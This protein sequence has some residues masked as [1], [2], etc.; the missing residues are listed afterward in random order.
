MAVTTAMRTQVSE[1]YVALFGRAPDAEGLGYWVEQMSNGRTWAQVAQD[2]YNTAPAR[3]YY[4]LS[5]TNEEI[6]TSFY[7]HVLGRQPDNEGKAYWTGQLNT[8]TEGQVVVDMITAVAN[9]TG[10]DPA[11]LASK[12]L[13]LNK[14]TVAQYYAFNLNGDAAGSVDAIADVTA[15]SNVSS[16]SN[17]EAL[18]SSGSTFVLTVDAPSVTEGNSGSKLLTF[19]LTLD[20]TP[21]QDV[22]VDYQT[23]TTGT[24][25]VNEDFVPGA[26]TVTFAAGQRTATVSV[27]VNG[28]TT[29]EA[30]ETIKVS[31]SGTKLAATVQGTGT[32]TNDDD[33]PPA[34]S[35]A[36]KTVGVAENSTTVTTSAAVDPD[37][38]QGAVTY[39]LTGDD[40]SK[41]AIDSNGNITFLV[42]PNYEAPGSNA[43][44]NAY[45]LTVNATSHGL[46]ASQTVTVNVTNVNENPTVSANSTSPTVNEN[47]TV[48]T[49]LTAGDPDSGDTTTYVLSGA[50]AAKFTIENGVLKFIT[51][52]DFETPTDAN[53][54]NV[55]AVSVQ[56]RDAG[57]LLSTAT[58]VNVT[59]ADVLETFTLT[60]SATDVIPGTPNDDLINGQVTDSLQPTTANTLHASDVIHGGDGND[61]LVVTADGDQP[62][63][64][65][66]TMDGVETLEV[67]SYT[68]DG[69][70]VGVDTGVTLGLV[71]VSGLETVES[72]N[73][74]SNI[75]LKYVQNLVDLDLS[76]NGSG[77]INVD[78]QYLGGAVAGASTQN[79]ALD[80]FG[81]T[82]TVGDVN[83]DGIETAAITTSGDA[84]DITLNSNDLTTVTVAGDQDLTLVVNGASAGLTTLTS[85]LT[86]AGLTATA[87]V[88]AGASVT[89]AAGDD[90]LFLSATAAASGGS[91]TV[92]AGEGD[93]TVFVDI[94][95]HANFNGSGDY[96][97][98]SSADLGSISVTTGDGDDTIVLL[99]A[100]NGGTDVTIDAGAGDNYVEVF[101]LT[102]AGNGLA[103]TV[104][105]TTGDG[106]DNI[107][108]GSAASLTVDMGN[109]TNTLSAG[110]ADTISITGGT[111]ADTV[112]LTSGGTLTAN[113]G[114]GENF[115]SGG[116]FTDVSITGG[117]DHDQVYIG[118]ADSVV[119]NTGDSTVGS[120]DYIWVGNVLSGDSSITTGNGNDQVYMDY[121][122]TG[123]TLTVALGEG[124]N[125]FSG[126]LF[127][128]I[129][130]TAGAGD[131]SITLDGASAGVNIDAGNGDNFV[132]IQN[133]GSG[134]PGTDVTITTGT[135][136]DLVWLGSAGNSANT[137]DT[138][139][140]TLGDG[141]DQIFIGNS[142]GLTGS[143]YTI[144]GGNGDDTLLVHSMDQISGGG[145]LANATSLETLV[146]AAVGSGSTDNFNAVSAGANDA[147]IV[148]YVFGGEVGST[149]YDIDDGDISGMEGDVGL[150]DVVDG[151]TVTSNQLADYNGSGNF[152]LTTVDADSEANWNIN[153]TG[154]N[155]GEDITVEGINAFSGGNVEYGQDNWGTVT[156]G[157]I[158]TF[159]LTVNDETNT[160]GG[161]DQNLVSGGSVGNGVY[162][163]GS[164]V[165]I[166]TLSA[167]DLTTLNIAGNASVDINS[168]SAPNLSM[169]DATDVVAGAVDNNGDTVAGNVS[170]WLD[171]V[172][173][174]IT[175]LTA[176]GDDSVVLSDTTSKIYA[177][178]GAGNDFVWGEDGNDTILTGAGDDLVYSMG[179]NDS[180]NTGE[181]NDTVVNLDGVDTIHTG[182]GDD[183]IY[184]S[185]GDYL[186]AAD[187][188]DGG[189]GYDEL[190]LQS[191]ITAAVDDNFFRQWSGVESVFLSGGSND[192]TLGWIAQHD[193]GI[194][195]VF[196]SNSGGD[197]LAL[198]VDYTT[199]LD[200]FLGT[201]SA[202]D[203]VD[204]SAMG[205]SGSLDVWATDHSMWH[206]G[207]LT[208]TLMGGDGNDTL[209]VMPIG[210]GGTVDLT[211]MHGFETV[212]IEVTP[213][214][215]GQASAADY[216]GNDV[217]LVFS[218]GN[219]SA[220]ETLVI[221]GS[222][223]VDIL[224]PSGGVLLSAGGLTVSGGAALGAFSITA[225][226]GDD[227]IHTGYGSDWI[228][229]G[230]GDNYAYTG[231]GGDDTVLGGD[232]NNT[233]FTGSGNATVTL[234]DGNN[235]VTTSAGDDTIVL[236]DGN[237]LVSAGAGN[238]YVSAGDGDNTIYAGDGDDEI[239]LGNGDNYVSA[240]SGD[241]T[242]TT[243]TGDDTVATGSG[244]DVISLGDGT[245]FV[246]AGEGADDL[247][248]GTGVDT[249]Y[250]S[251]SDESTGLTVDTIHGFEGGAGGDIISLYG[252][253]AASAASGGAVVFLGTVS[254]STI[255]D[256]A[257]V[258]QT[259]GGT[260]VGPYASFNLIYVSGEHTLYGDSNCNG[261][262]DGG[263]MAIDLVGL[264]GTLAQA[265]FTA[266]DPFA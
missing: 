233:V 35:V 213:T 248:G 62:N 7:V 40:A 207:G 66:F 38:G 48:V 45:N 121:S 15:N 10:S 138:L 252:T 184:F 17:I 75:T 129:T 250:Y 135:G 185:A 169:I 261:V 50:D 130:V 60:T 224:G 92:N 73:S 161:V 126:G 96:I 186:T 47:T 244:A 70:D 175:V 30:A 113:L 119:I 201:G 95:N 36:T 61:R 127:H 168:I 236:G 188:V 6:V 145:V 241:N 202:A 200:V 98:T 234:G 226:D 105:I 258:D 85:T 181:G 189:D 28:D 112:Q 159:N 3:T 197:S 203:L 216:A 78:V 18:I 120:G 211:E 81:G 165:N 19:T 152:T 12:A 111:G 173:A 232:G 143:E 8:K 180:V 177:D 27:T 125:T 147:G 20:S 106:D 225:G 239:H 59:V 183:Q 167:G 68:L 5:M 195:N 37:A 172:A 108:V 142:A 157:N 170:V 122:S 71:N 144:A 209:H 46:T 2:M 80:N 9:Y 34:F 264:T 206:S 210:S 164:G 33:N 198:N 53:A 134:G 218:A 51:A 23:L 79:I 187:V 25:A 231:S 255:A 160:A 247:T 230:A 110:Y 32:V 21:A 214:L 137:P 253:L 54:D 14:A 103:G 133:F 77:D 74:T 115:I 204:G 222:Q 109:G 196:L 194:E 101:T 132:R 254:N 259:V 223:M 136:D 49:T 237:N 242:I 86:G 251:N 212:V 82:I 190:Y 158:A 221:D 149:A 171:D 84:S 116:G 182:A 11:A 64:N 107:V 262:I 176:A 88:D 220:G 72:T 29:V 191:T 102:S 178:T 240:G 263:D 219:V 229:L 124:N 57:G 131:D 90:N 238:N 179:G 155:N 24:A 266:V 99:S 55:Y 148:N 52:P 174:S 76:S 199:N 257:L 100:G 246:F 228:Q 63:V 104:S 140:V 217:T 256:T 162:V 97:S 58:N 44:T 208:D 89:T 91:L 205:T 245:N 260:V 215:P 193:A 31:F 43:G 118:S 39:Q 4:P 151:V 153:L 13:L 128:D 154:Y 22:T 235:E 26:G 146:F 114:A 83:G 150:L 163:V 265:N 141:N 249:F 41:F 42:A 94:H 16:S 1:L 156:L 67:R 139:S 227:S 87:D 243:G 65:G 192:L 117:A 69:S 166:D 123:T 56:S 93:N